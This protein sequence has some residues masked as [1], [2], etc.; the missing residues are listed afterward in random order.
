MNNYWG[1]F[2]IKFNLI[3]NMNNSCWIYNENSTAFYAPVQEYL[4]LNSSI[5]PAEVIN[6]P[7]Y[8]QQPE[9]YSN[10]TYIQSGQKTPYSGS[11]PLQLEFNKAQ[12]IQEAEKYART[13]L[14]IKN[15][16]MQGDIELAN[17]VNEGLTEIYNKYKG[18][19]PMPAN[20]IKAAGKGDALYNYKSDTLAVSP[21]NKKAVLKRL[22]LKIDNTPPNNKKTLSNW[23]KK[24][25]RN[26]FSQVNF[27]DP[28][29][30]KAVALH[31][32]AF[33][34]NPNAFDITESRRLYHEINALFEAA[35]APGENPMKLIEELY[36]NPKYKKILNNSDFNSLSNISKFDKNSQTQEFYRII[37]KLKSKGV[38]AYI[39]PQNSENNNEFHVIYHEYGHFR[40]FKTTSYNA[41]KKH[42]TEFK[43]NPYK[44]NTAKQVSSYAKTEP[45]EFVAEVYAGLLNGNKYSKEVMALYRSYNG[46][47]VPKQ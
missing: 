16:D 46:P 35:D 30:Q 11:K 47:Y 31:I 44:Q 45:M 15:F 39:E 5:F 14:G 2:D 10:V 13:K 41:L 29:F 26:D 22:L 28:K 23:Y 7:H 9:K 40:H 3:K 8:A 1:N 24:A 43:T 27:I 19:A 34:E 36:N 42:N 20:V 32:K 38:K 18:Q 12:T 6:K 21:D 37:N 33:K 25:L 4:S 17:W